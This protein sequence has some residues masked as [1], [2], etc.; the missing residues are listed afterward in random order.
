MLQ[1]LL[2][3]DLNRK[4]TVPITDPSCLGVLGRIT[5]FNANVEVNQRGYF[6]FHACVTSVLS[7]Y[8]L[9]AIAHS[10][11]F[12]DVVGS[13]Y[14]KMIKAELP[15][16][17]NVRGVARDMFPDTIPRPKVNLSAV[18]P[19]SPGDDNYASHVHECVDKQNVHLWKHT[20]SCVRPNCDCCRVAKGSGFCDETGSLEVTI[21]TVVDHNGNGERFWLTAQ[22]VKE[23]PVKEFANNECTIPPIDPR[24]ITFELKRRQPAFRNKDGTELLPGQD[25]TLL[26]WLDNAELDGLDGSI[27]DHL[28]TCTTA[29]KTEFKYRVGKR[30]S[31]VTEYSEPLMAAVASNMAVYPIGSGSSAKTAQM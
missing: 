28:Q 27:R 13:I 29:E 30:N 19:P 15:L 14:D 12:S 3:V 8:I 23:L 17:V 18:V 21:T 11:V 5:D 2:G 25:P 9:S 20:D 24:P 6:H 7:P 26:D 10:K 31:F 16:L 1:C 22:R 4:R